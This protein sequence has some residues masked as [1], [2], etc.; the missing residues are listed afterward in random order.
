VS[1]SSSKNVFWFDDT[2]SLIWTSEPQ[3]AAIKMNVNINLNI[4][5]Y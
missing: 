1:P 2:I 3:S 4:F 5:L